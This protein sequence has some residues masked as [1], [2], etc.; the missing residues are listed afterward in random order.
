MP[1][2]GAALR[3]NRCL[4]GQGSKVG[5]RRSSVVRETIRNNTDLA[6]VF[7]CENRNSASGRA[8]QRRSPPALPRVDF[9]CE[10]VPRVV[11]SFQNL[12]SCLLGLV[13][14]VSWYTAVFIGRFRILHFEIY[15]HPM[16][17][18]V[19]AAPDLI[20]VILVR[21]VYRNLLSTSHVRETRE[22]WKF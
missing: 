21:N 20:G 19:P 8:L 15:L 14:I 17:S 13:H 9:V 4:R 6:D 7:V 10:S 18:L 2:V 16:F 12:V 1:A 22:V 3:L 11:C 5:D